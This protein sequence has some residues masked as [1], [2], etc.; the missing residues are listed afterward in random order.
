M[1]KTKVDPREVRSLIQEIEGTKSTLR[2]MQGRLDYIRKN[3][4]HQWGEPQYAPDIQKGY[5]IPADPPG[6]FGVDWRGETYVPEVRTDRWTRT[7]KCCLLVET[8]TK[9]ESHVTKT[10][11][12]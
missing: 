6:K 5:R 2:G 7:C 12:F 4:D 8:T 1:S 3:C 11:K 9:T 10:P